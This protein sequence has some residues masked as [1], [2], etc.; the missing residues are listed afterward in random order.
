[1]LVSRRVIVGLGWWFGI[2]RVPLSN[3]PFHKELELVVWGY[4][5]FFVEGSWDDPPSLP[6]HIFS[7]HQKIMALRALERIPDPTSWCFELLSSG[8]LEDRTKK[9]GKLNFEFQ[10]AFLRSQFVK[11]KISNRTNRPTYCGRLPATRK[12]RMTQLKTSEVMIFWGE[13]QS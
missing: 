3:N 10:D 8:A 2:L 9:N 11:A 7:D 13:L 6:P 5:S 4:V 1:M 12:T